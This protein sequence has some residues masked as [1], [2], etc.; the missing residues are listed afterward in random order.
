MTEFLDMAITVNPQIMD[1]LKAVLHQHTKV[2]KQIDRLGMKLF[3]DR[4]EEYRDTPVITTWE[5]LLKMLVDEY[6]KSIER[7]NE[8]EL[9]AC[10]DRE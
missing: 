6:W 7:Q 4:A 3:N 9:I 10:F 8:A 5:A 1:E 2:H